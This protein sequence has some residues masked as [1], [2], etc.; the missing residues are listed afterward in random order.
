[1]GDFPVTEWCAD[2]LLS[3]P[4][5]AEMNSEAIGYVIDKVIE[6]VK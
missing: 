4:I 1:V 2:S 5:Y 6:Y 3:L